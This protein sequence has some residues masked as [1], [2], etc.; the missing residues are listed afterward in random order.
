MFGIDNSTPIYKGNGQP[1]TSGGGFLSG[2]L[3][4]LFGGS[5]TPTYKGAGQPGAKSS[6]LAGLIPST[7]AYK[8]APSADTQES[9]PTSAQAPASDGA[10]LDCMATD[11]DPPPIFV[12]IQ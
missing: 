10:Q 7:P 12:R 5:G 1:S 11:G 4:Y 8:A 9:A 2:I 3:G 6:R